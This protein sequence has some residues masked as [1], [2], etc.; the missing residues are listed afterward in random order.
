M[1]D[2]L[3]INETVATPIETFAL[4]T[5][6]DEPSKDHWSTPQNDGQ[7]WRWQLRPEVIEALS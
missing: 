3:Q 6:A 5:D 4:A 1:H 7:H 2:L